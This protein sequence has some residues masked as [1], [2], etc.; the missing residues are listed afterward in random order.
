[1]DIACHYL[2]DILLLWRKCFHDK[3]QKTTVILEAKQNTGEWRGEGYCGAMLSAPWTARRPRRVTAIHMRSTVSDQPF[4]GPNLIGEATL[5]VLEPGGYRKMTAVGE[6]R[7]HV[8]HKYGR[9]TQEIARLRQ[10]R[11]SGDIQRLN[12]SHGHL[13]FVMQSR[14]R[15]N[16]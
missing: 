1:M 16:I 10:F 3:N 9:F 5:N 12:L 8:C 14:V 6:E 7:L 2:A 15:H 4:N 13:S 11:S